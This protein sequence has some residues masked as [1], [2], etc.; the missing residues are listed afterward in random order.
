MIEL[1]NY[2][3][4]ESIAFVGS[5]GFNSGEPLRVLSVH[6]FVKYKLCTGVCSLLFTYRYTGRFVGPG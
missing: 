2:L 5:V 4:H 6:V 1:F 3:N